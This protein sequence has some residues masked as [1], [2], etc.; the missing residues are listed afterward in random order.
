MYSLASRGSFGKEKLGLEIRV[1]QARIGSIV[2]LVEQIENLCA[3]KTLS[4]S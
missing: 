4:T 1:Q 2:Y 3:K